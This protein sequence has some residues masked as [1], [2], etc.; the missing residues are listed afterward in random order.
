MEKL[1]QAIVK[2]LNNLKQTI[3]IIVPLVLLIGLV[4]SVLTKEF[5]ASVFS[6]NYFID[7]LIGGV[8]GS[9]SAGNPITSYILGGE[10]LNNGISLIAVTSFLLA[11][12]TV[13]LIQFPAESM[14]LGKKFALVRNIVSFVFAIII[15]ILTVITMNGLG[16]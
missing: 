8:I 11:W 13:G 15:S 9:I 3:P 5:Y 1:N 14:L 4:T 12:V 10:F 2:T 16:L 6:G 7:S